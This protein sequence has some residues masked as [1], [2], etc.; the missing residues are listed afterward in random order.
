MSDIIRVINQTPG[1][2]LEWARILGGQFADEFAVPVPNM[3]G[4]Q[5]Y[6]I[7]GD[8]EVIK[9]LKGPTYELLPENDAFAVRVG[10]LEINPLAQFVSMDGGDRFDEK[11]GSV[12][13]K[14]LN[15]IYGITHEQELPEPEEGKVIEVAY[16]KTGTL[17]ELYN[18]IEIIKS[19][20]V[21]EGRQMIWR[22]IIRTSGIYVGRNDVR[23]R[24]YKN[25]NFGGRL[26]GIALSGLDTVMGRFL[27]EAVGDLHSGSI[28]YDF[29]KAYA[30]EFGPSLLFFSNDELCE[31]NSIPSDWFFEIVGNNCDLGQ[32]VRYTMGVQEY[33][34]R[35]DKMIA[36]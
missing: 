20:Q 32:E 7:V 12:P 15:P 16:S 21:E 25:T 22:A 5:F 35:T 36:K 33:K 18:D 9:Y 31:M 24:G 3:S 23:I 27:D 4:D 10:G 14:I 29:G 17:E 19:F 6:G 8:Y 28:H 2:L 11:L 30:T 13:F 1:S 26:S 34:L